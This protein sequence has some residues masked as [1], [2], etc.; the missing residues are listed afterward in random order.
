MNLIIDIGNTRTK[1][2]IFGKGKLLRKAVFETGWGV[3]ALKAFI[4]DRPV[5]SAAVSTVAGLDK[6]IEHYL[7]GLKYYLKLTAATPLPLKNNY[8][9]P[10]TLGND[11]L[12][13]VAGA[14]FL[15]PGKACL[16]IDAG[17]CITYDFISAKGVYEGG[18]ITPGINMRLKAM[19]TFTSGLPLV[20]L[21]K[22][23]SSVGKDTR[24]SILTG[25]L[26]GALLEME[27][28]IKHYEAAFGTLTAILTGGDADYFANKM[29]SEIFVNPNLV[30]I[31]LN[32][33]LNYNVQY[34][35]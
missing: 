34:S 10:E 2:G 28:F 24:T 16:A 20:P 21:K 12:A 7:A 9:S 3:N 19:H 13:A 27:G 5:E 25:A 17:T 1:L 33:I 22:T 26:Q 29:K 31:G 32:Q 15:F 4:A 6:N 23:N 14:H 8:K 18:N 35:K 30:L 11:R